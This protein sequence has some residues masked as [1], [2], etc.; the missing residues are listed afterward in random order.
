MR[1]LNGPIGSS[2]RLGVGGVTSTSSERSTE[3][4]I[5]NNTIIAAKVR[6]TRPRSFLTRINLRRFESLV[7]ER[8]HGTLLRLRTTPLTWQGILLGKG[9]GCFIA[10]FAITAFLL[11]IGV[12]IFQVRIAQPLGLL[13][14]LTASSLGFTGI[15]LLIATLGKTERAVA[16]AA[17]GIF[18]PLAML[19]GGMIP[20]FFMPSW[21]QQAA[22]ISPFKWGILA[23]EGAIWRGFTAGDYILPCFM[24]LLFGAIGF[25]LGC[26]LLT[27]SQAS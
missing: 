24:L 7:S 27:K 4:A 2:L 12:V 25:S 26:L 20:L 8:T 19:G 22:S 17:S 9:L 3:I 14:A 13:V 23:F 10:C 11:T 21:L 5:R 18:M 6:I 15:M 16:G 1:K